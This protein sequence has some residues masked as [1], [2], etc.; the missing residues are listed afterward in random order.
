MVADSFHRTAAK[1]V[2]RRRVPSVS[3]WL[4]SSPVA[5]P[6]STDVVARSRRSVDESPAPGSPTVTLGSV[7][8]VAVAGVATE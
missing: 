8:R 4:A 1:L 7:T 6:A 5:S 3:T 2:S